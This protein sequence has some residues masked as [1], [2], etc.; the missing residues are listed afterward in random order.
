ML[1]LMRTNLDMNPGMEDRCIIEELN[2]GESVPEGIPRQPDVLLLADCVYLEVAFQPLV[3]T[4]V[5]MTNG[6]TEVLVS[7]A[8]HISVTQELTQLLD[9]QFCYQQRRKADKRFFKLLTKHFKFHDIDDDDQ[10]R[11]KEYTRQGTR[12]YKVIKKQ[13]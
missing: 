9:R 13:T 1:A 12:L 8:I 5:S 11:Q 2:W 7:V 6:Q 10:T 4:M 3:D